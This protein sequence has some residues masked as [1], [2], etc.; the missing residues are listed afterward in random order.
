MG[1]EAHADLWAALSDPAVIHGMCEDYR[2]GLA[3]DA[4]HDRTDRAVRRWRSGATE[5]VQAG[6]GVVGS[7][8]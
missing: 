3:I 2:A 7:A 5:R 6:A 8:I 1:A 4:E